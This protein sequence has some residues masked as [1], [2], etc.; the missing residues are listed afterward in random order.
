MR[1]EIEQSLQ[2]LKTLLVEV[3]DLRS[4]GAL[5]HWDQATYMPEGGAPA[6]GRQLATLSRLAH[7]KFTSPRLG[8]LL[9]ELRPLELEEPYES[10]IAA[11]LRVT[12]REY[13]KAVRIP[14]A[15][16][17]KFSAHSAQIY[18]AWTKARPANDFASVRPLLEKSLDLSRELASFFPHEHI[19]DPLIDFSDGGMKTASIRTL[20]A[21]LR[22]QLVPLVDEVTS[23]PPADTSVLRAH[24]PLR[25]QE[26][27]TYEAVRAFGYDFERGR[28]DKTHHPFMTKF[29]LGDVRITNRAR[30]DD[31]TELLFGSL[32]ETGH[33]LYEQGIAP[34][35]EGTPLAT[36]TSS[37]V[38]ESQSRLWENLVGRS[39]GFWQ[40]F[41]PRLQ[42]IFPDQLGSV[43]PDKFLAAINHVERSLI[44]TDADELTYN[45]HVM[46]RFDL[47]IEMLEGQ[48]EVR[49]LP[50]A[51]R[52][53]YQSD[54]SIA[55]ADDANGPLQDVHWFSGTIGGAFQ[56]YTIGNILSAQFFEAAK[57][58]NPEVDA[59]IAR[60]EFTPLREWLT[61]NVYRHG[62]KFTA[63]EITLRATGAELSIEPYLNYLRGKF[64]GS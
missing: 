48:L 45:L 58:A 44:R 53:R 4:A 28:M 47:E 5:L 46:I 10:D 49:D 21:A 25:D 55:P 50:A 37:G 42:S 52:A 15:F 61:Q 60:G 41:Y 51:W 18:E 2:E 17:A 62:S 64:L 26:Q 19:A 16:E 22:A 13:L 7:E 12:R 35:L 20:F 43:S 30:E 9:H 6:R 8:E 39:A 38:H 56:G 24:F 63:D 14:P 59:Q 32:H 57:R 23:R 36:G 1:P 33:A 34:D 54:L 11:L 27:F 31:L 40:H 3:N 29:S